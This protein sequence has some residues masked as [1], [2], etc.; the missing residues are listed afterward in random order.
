[1]LRGVSFGAWN[2]AW[3]NLTAVS[4][5]RSSDSTLADFGLVWQ[6]STI[7]LPA[8]TPTIPFVATVCV[9]G[10]PNWR[11]IAAGVLLDEVATQHDQLPPFAPIVAIALTAKRPL[12]AGVTV[13]T[14]LFPV[15]R[16]VVPKYSCA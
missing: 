4:A 3:L 8:R 11:F 7:E 12:D 10:V 13:A 1:L 6:T 14:T 5:A 16:P 9:R 15:A 2:V